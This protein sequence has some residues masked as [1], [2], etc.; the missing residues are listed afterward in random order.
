MKIS[1]NETIQSWDPAKI[2]EISSGSIIFIKGDDKPY[3]VILT[4]CVVPVEKEEIFV[5]VTVVNN[6]AFLEA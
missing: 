2:V 5:P 3:R 1:Q 4:A 6:E